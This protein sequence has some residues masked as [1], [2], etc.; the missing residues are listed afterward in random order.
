M[1]ILASALISLLQL[2][3]VEAA[4]AE[5]LRLNNCIQRIETDP[6]GAYE[7]GLTWSFEGNRPGARYC[8][9]L[10]LI[11]LDQPGEGAARLES[12]ANATDSGNLAERAIYLA[13][14]GNAWIN[15]GAPEAAVI[16]LTNALKLTPRDTAILKDRASAH[17]LLQDWG[18]AQVDLDTV[19]SS[20]SSDGEALRM[21]ASVHRNLENLQSALTDIKAAM[22][23][24]PQNIDTLVLRGEI[25]EDIRK[26]ELVQL[27]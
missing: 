7:D 8:T 6:E 24:D 26:S 12:L 10:S 11:A 3:G 19:I 15:A 2:T 4:Q 9:A 18:N 23:A 17:M 16:A 1:S 14:A 22:A 27:D 13:Q 20:Q 5:Q 25:R 21:R